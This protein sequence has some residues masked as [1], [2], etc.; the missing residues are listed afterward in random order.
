MNEKPNTDL[1]LIET[2]IAKGQ[3]K[4][5]L[6]PIEKLALENPKNARAW[7][8]L[9]IVKQRLKNHKQ[10]EK[11]LLHSIELDETDVDAHCSLGGVYLSLGDFKKATVYFEKG[12][13]LSGNK[14]TFALLNYLVMR[15]REGT[16]DEALSRLDDALDDGEARCRED[17]DVGRNLPW[18]SF[19]L[20]QIHLLRGDMELCREAIT[21]A[22][23]LASAIWQLDSATYTYRLLAE[24]LNEAIRTRAMKVVDLIDTLKSEYFAEPDKKRCFVIMPFGKKLDEADVEVNFDEVYNN[25]I[26]PTVEGEGLKCIRCDEVDEAGNIHK[27]MFQLIWHADVAIADVSIQNP[28]V[29]YELGI[30]H[31]LRKAVTVIIRN[32]NA[33]LP[34]NIANMNAVDYDFTDGKGDDGARTR[35]RK[36]IS[37]GLKAGESDSHVNEILNLNI[38][39]RPRVIGSCNVYSYPIKNTGKTLS[40][41]TGDLRSVRGIDVWVNSE[42]TNMQM[43]RYFDFAISSVIR[44]EGARK[45]R[46]GHVIDDLIQNELDEI[47]DGERSVSEAAVIATGPGEL[48]KK[49]GVKAI[50]HAASV[51]GAVGEGYEPIRGIH[52]CVTNALMLMDDP[53]KNGAGAKLSSILIPLLG[54]GFVRGDFRPLLERQVEAAIEYVTDHPKSNVDN[55]YILAWSEQELALCQSVFR[56]FESLGTPVRTKQKNLE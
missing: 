44:F 16:L 36:A 4:R 33:S 15:S 37:M 17:I 38:F 12:L 29:F 7:K 55:V 31:A 25:F 18:S 56:S 27:R 32:K 11:H 13:D 2:W 8:N 20:A 9:G 46:A 47:M 43:A 28:N 54:I 1:V 23:R 21:Q 50:F 40:L 48:E 19:D 3:F 49:Y 14:S 42:N 52:R 6:K 5:A 41:I 24:S 53:E 45:N 30:R 34:F 10:A 22:V 51:R 26:K 39:D 35:I